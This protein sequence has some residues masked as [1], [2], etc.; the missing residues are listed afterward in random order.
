MSRA[1]LKRSTNLPGL[2]S[3]TAGGGYPKPCACC[4]RRNCFVLGS[5][6]RFS[7]ISI[8]APSLSIREVRSIPTWVRT[9]ALRLN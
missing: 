8:C 9:Q 7:L 2:S 5:P 4:S 1:P 6:H 3:S